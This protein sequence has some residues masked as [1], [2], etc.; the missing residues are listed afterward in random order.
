MSECT[1]RP[2]AILDHSERRRDARLRTR[3]S[4][5]APNPTAEHCEVVARG[6]GCP[7]PSLVG[8]PSPG[9]GDPLGHAGHM[10]A[11]QGRMTSTPISKGNHGTSRL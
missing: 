8:Q 2:C 6:G 1:E 10:R 7:I 5:A 4:C 3:P 11:G 9:A